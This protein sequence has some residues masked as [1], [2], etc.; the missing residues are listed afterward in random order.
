MTYESPA[1][2]RAALEDRLQNEARNRDIDLGRLRRRAVFERILVRLESEQ[3]G[4]WVVKG[5]IALEVRLK[6][7]ARATKDLDLAIREDVTSG[8][9]VRDLIVEGLAVDVDGDGFRFEVGPPKDITAEMGGRPGWRFSIEA[10]LAGKQFAQVR[11]DVV[12]RRPDEVTETQRVSL[13][14]SM[15]FAGF[16]TRQ[17]EVVT[18]TQHFAEKLHAFT[19]N[20][21]DRENS[22]VRDLADMVLLIEDGF[23]NP[24]SVFSA[25]ERVFRDRKTHKVPIEIPDPPSSWAPIYD[26]M[27][28]ELDIQAPNVDDAMKIVRNFWNKVRPANPESEENNAQVG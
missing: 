14:G 8:D 12:A 25:V 5:A 6:E 10:S 20:Y 1:A 18:A 24:A 27:A 2:L 15:T 17:V 7:R 3:P 26:A 23:E 9:E 4:T 13:P 28:K 21:G 22:R 19:R 16:P 11:L